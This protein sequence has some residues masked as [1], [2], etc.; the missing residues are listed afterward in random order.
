MDAKNAEVTEA[1]LLAED[2]TSR[3]V[4]AWERVQRAEH[5]IAHDV[6]AEP[7]AREIARHGVLLAEAKLVLLRQVDR[8]S[9]G[10][11]K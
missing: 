2:L 7:F 1:I 6:D 11:K 10:E 8:F 4:L 9:K 3:A 5:A